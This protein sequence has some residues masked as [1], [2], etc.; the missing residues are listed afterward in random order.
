MKAVFTFEFLLFGAAMFGMALLA[1]HLN[2]NTGTLN[3]ILNFL[4]SS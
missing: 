2:G 1:A 3:D 4:Q